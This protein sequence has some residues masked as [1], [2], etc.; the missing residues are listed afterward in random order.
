[1]HRPKI[2][3]SSPAPQPGGGAPS[4]KLASRVPRPGKSPGPQCKP[5][6]RRAGSLRSAVSLMRLPRTT[7]PMWTHPSVILLGGELR[8]DTGIRA[9]HHLLLTEG[10]VDVGRTTR[11]SVATRSKPRPRRPYR[12]RASL[13]RA[14]ARSVWNSRRAFAIF[15]YHRAMQKRSGHGRPRPLAVKAWRIQPNLLWIVPSET[16]P[17][18]TSGV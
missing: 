1:M 7:A 17:L 8:F 14:G 4:A 15:D 3:P 18:E 9:L 12:R 11:A 2:P 16:R 10:R 13:L 5:C 6:E